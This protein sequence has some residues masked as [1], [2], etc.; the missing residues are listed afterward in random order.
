[1]TVWESVSTTHQWRW[2]INGLTLKLIFY[3]KIWR[4]STCISRLEHRHPL[5]RR[6]SNIAQFLFWSLTIDQTEVSLIKVIDHY[7]TLEHALRWW[8]ISWGPK[9]TMITLNKYFLIIINIYRTTVEIETS[10][11]LHCTNIYKGNVHRA[12]FGL[13]GNSLVISAFCFQ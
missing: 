3:Y 1:M 12:I 4:K 8:L 6:A 11:S 2:L 9:A 10:F 5:E 7:V 13:S